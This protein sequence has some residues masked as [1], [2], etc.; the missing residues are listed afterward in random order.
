MET[1]KQ[2]E[3]IPGRVSIIIP[4]YN[5]EKSIQQTLDSALSQDYPDLE[6]LVINDGSTDNTASILLENADND[7]RVKVFTIP[8][9]GPSIARKKG[10]DEATGEYYQFLDADDMLYPDAIGRLMAVAAADNA[11]MVALSFDILSETGTKQPSARIIT[12]SIS[13][14]DALKKNMN[15][16]YWAQWSMFTKASL[17]DKVIDF[18]EGMIYGEDLI[19][20]VQ[21]LFNAGKVSVGEVPALVYNVHSGS[22]STGPLSERRKRDTEKYMSWVYE[23]LQHNQCFP[24]FE[25]AWWG[26]KKFT[27]LLKI[28]ERWLGN[29]SEDFV[30]MW[31]A[32]E[33]YPNLKAGFPHQIEKLCKVYSRSKLLGYIKLK[34]YIHKGRI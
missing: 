5:A 27:L 19:I 16:G 25:E 13:G 11:D 3:I 20:M 10:I 26:L 4:C 14:K 22:I 12:R 31:E 6:I 8:N 15:G 30:E 23:F 2:K 1:S 29:I 33:K 7:S 24:D 9:S 21:L 28:S 18:G 17:Y 32:L 34:K